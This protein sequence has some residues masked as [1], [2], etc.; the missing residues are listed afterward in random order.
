[1]FVSSKVV[2]TGPQPDQQKPLIMTRGGMVGVSARGAGDLNA[3][4][5]SLRN[6]GMEIQATDAHFGLV[7]GYL[8]IAQLPNAIQLPQSRGIDPIY[9]PYTRAGSVPNEADIN[10]GSDQARQ[11]FGLDGTGVQ[12]G[13][14]SD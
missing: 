4:A 7:E 9:T 5:Q 2:Q 6:L 1:N 8:P 13:V 14:L 12:I 10:F 11:Q 3:F